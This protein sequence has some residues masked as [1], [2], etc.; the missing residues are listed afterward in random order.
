MASYTSYF[1]LYD[2]EIYFLQSKLTKLEKK[3]LVIKR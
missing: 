3:T 2:I 1:L